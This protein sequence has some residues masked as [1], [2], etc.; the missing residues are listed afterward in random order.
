[1]SQYEVLNSEKHRQIRIKTGY[2]AALG[3]AV[4]Y[5]MTY[6][7][8]FRDIQGSYPILFTKEPNTGGFF[9]AALLGFE[10]DQN[11]FLRDGGWD[12]TYVPTLVQRQPF[13]IAKVGEDDTKPPV[14]SLDLDHPRISRDEGEA[15]FDS[16]GEPSEFLKQ[17]IGLLDKLHRGLQHGSGFIN[18][19]LQHELLV[20]ITLDIAFNDGSK[21]TLQGF[22]GIAEERLYQLKGDV[23]ESLNQAGYLQPVFMAVASLSR[24]RDLI[25]RRNRLRV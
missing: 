17:K 14:V 4:M 18:T 19:L 12:A 5:A 24:V 20:Q 2:G 7:M 21:K 1:M 8:E 9:A 16:G 22:Y 23:L 13:L 11:L 10:A 3:D 15:L 6:P 25:E